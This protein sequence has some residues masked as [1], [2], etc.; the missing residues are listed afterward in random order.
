MGLKSY[1][2][3]STEPNIIK[4]VLSNADRIFDA[5]GGDV[6][7]S[8]DYIIH[9]FTGNGTF[10]V[11]SGTASIEYLIVAGGGGGGMDMGG[12]GG[13]G[14]VVIGSSVVGKGTYTVTVGSGGVGAP[15]AGTNGQPSAH[16][17]TIPATK[18]GDSSI[19]GIGVTAIGGGFGGS[20][21]RGYTP[22]IA[23]GSGGSGGGSSGYND[24]AGTFLGGQGTTGQGNRGGNSTAA[25]YSGGGGGAGG[26]GA[27]STNQPNGGDG[28]VSAIL[29]TSYFWGGGGGG[30][31]YSLANG[32]NGGKGGGGGGAVG[33]T[34]GGTGFNDGAPGGGGSPNSQTNRPG[35]DGGINTGGGGGGGSHYNANNKGGNGGSGIV[36][37]RY[38]SSN[39]SPPN[40]INPYI[41]MT[42]VVSANLTLHNSRMARSANIF[43]TSGSSSWDNQAYSLTQFSAPCTIEFNKQAASGDNGVSYAMIGWNEDPTTNASYTSLDYASY[44]YRTDTYAV[45][46]NG[47][48]VHFSG[49]WS[50]TNKFYI[51]YD[52][53][54]FIR[55]YNGSTLLYSVN[56]GTGKTVYVDSSFYSVNST[57]GGF[58]NIKVSR[59][60]W[61]GTSYV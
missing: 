53:D 17:F 42:Y 18:G 49:T 43:K 54:G 4:K 21:Y 58:S 31:S 35:G 59:R 45:Y 32:G 39:T 8:G 60:S 25:Y 46:H 16:Q 38:K 13:A 55:H 2:L 37:I 1:K 51:V 48:L 27:D 36:V 20:S 22:G 44:P 34:T 14:G 26:Q 15:A 33:T 57:F 56:Y 5:V 52:T 28:I 3:S 10:T 9:T 7:R 41:E 47:S 19:A 29:G 23:G 40:T 50:T 24:N 30:A 61:N 11:N 12:G 6:S